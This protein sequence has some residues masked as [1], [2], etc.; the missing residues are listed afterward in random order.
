MTVSVSVGVSAVLAANKLSVIFIHTGGGGEAGSQNGEAIS[1]LLKKNGF[2]VRG[3]DN[4]TDTEGGAGVDYFSLEDKG[5]ATAVAK[6]VT[7]GLGPGATP[8]LP[9]YQSKVPNPPGFLGVWL[10]DPGMTGAAAPAN[11]T[12]PPKVAWC[13]QEHDPK[14][15]K[16]LVACHF[17]K[18]NCQ[19]ARGPN[20]PLP[21]TNCKY[22]D[23]SSAGWA[24]KPN[25]LSNSWYQNSDKPFP[26]PFPQIDENDILQ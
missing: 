8:V 26:E 21:G 20:N 1:T 7:E 9:R 24:P 12:S 15:G 22:T 11:W 16:Y 19:Q 13:Y 3:V 17:N 25:G 6:V 2:Y 10:Y 18:T 4:L 5:L 14:L 23:L